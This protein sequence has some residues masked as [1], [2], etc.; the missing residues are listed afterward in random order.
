MMLSN[1]GVGED[2]C[3]SLGQQGDQT[4]LSLRKSTLNIHSG[5]V[6]G[7]ERL[8]L[9]LKLQYFGHLVQRTDS[10]EKT[11][12]LGKIEGKRRR[13]WQRI[14]WLDNITN[15]MDTNFSNFQETEEPG[16]LQSM[17]LQTVGHHLA[18]E[19]QQSMYSPIMLF[20]HLWKKYLRG[21]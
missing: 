8:M 6:Q 14:R 2:S 18:T 3:E 17:G 5:F 7:S 12:M 19:Q 16:V 4:S 1:C 11:L 10:L 13:G 21:S 20:I 9:K 15:S